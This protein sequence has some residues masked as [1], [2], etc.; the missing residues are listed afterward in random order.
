MA[1]KNCLFLATNG[2]VDS[3]KQS[4]DLGKTL[5]NRLVVTI[6]HKNGERHLRNSLNR[7]AVIR[8]AASHFM[9]IEGKWTTFSAARIPRLAETTKRKYVDFFFVFFGFFFSW[10]AGGV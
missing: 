6:F 1:V 10:R 3:F 8:S 5:A 9:K 4:F 2:K 7:I